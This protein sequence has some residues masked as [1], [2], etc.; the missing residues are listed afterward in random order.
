MKSPNVLNQRPLAAPPRRKPGLGMIGVGAFGEFCVPHLRRSFELS[1]FDPRC[2]LG[3][4]CESH[5]AQ[6]AGLPE[7][8]RQDVVVLAVPFRQLRAVAREIAPHLKAGSLV[9]DV[10]SVKTKPL[11]VLAEELPLTVD[12]VGTHPLFGPQSG[13]NGIEGRRIAVCPLR[14]RKAPI[15]ERFLRR[16]FGLTVSRMTALEHDREMAH[17]QGLTHLISRIVMAMDL[18]PVEHATATYAHLE[19]MVNTVRHDSD[20]LFRTIVADNPF[21]GEVMLSFVRATKDVL[22]PFGYPSNGDA[23]SSG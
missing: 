1:L 13:R 6:A 11:S 17:V 12:I 20:E 23:L 4:I 18:P 16:Q 15:L 3:A 8:A 19:T 14:G 21:A 2:D 5:G 22:Q 7:V 9:V 10:C